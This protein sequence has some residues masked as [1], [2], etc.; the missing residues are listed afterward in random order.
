MG[1]RNKIPVTIRPKGVSDAQD[2]SNAF[3]GA[4]VSLQN[5]VLAYHTAN[6]FVPRPAAVKVVDFTGATPANPNGVISEMV[7]IGSRVY[8]MVSSAQFAGKD[9]PFCYDL[10]TNAFIPIAGVI[11]AL[12][13]NSPNA[14]GDWVPPVMR[15]IT[16]T[17]ILCTHPGFPGG[18]IPGVYFGWIDTS[19]Y[20]QNVIGNTTNGSN[21][22]SSLYTTIGNSAPIL[23]GVQPGQLITNV[24]FPAGTYVISCQNGTFSL[25]T[26]GNTTSGSNAL[27]GI[28]S[29]AGVLP[30]MTVSGPGIPSGTY[31]LTVSGATATMSQNATA[32]SAA[33]V[34]L[35]F[36]GGGSITVSANAT[37]SVNT[38][39]VTVSGGTPAAPRWGAG[40]FNSNSITTIP[41]CCY[42][43]NSR[44]YMGSGPYLVYSDPLMPLQVSAASQALLIGDSTDITALAG[45]PL[46]SQLTGGVQQSMTVFKGAGTLWQVTGD[47]AADNFSVDGVSYVINGGSASDNLTI[48]AV[49]GSVGTL[50]PRSIVGTPIGTMFMAVDGLRVLG[51]TGTLSEPLNTDGKGVAI[52]FLNALYPSRIVSAY[53]ENIYRATVQDASQPGNPIVE[54]WFDINSGVW[55]GPHTLTTR[56]AQPYISGASFLVAPLSTNG[57]IWRSDAI[58]NYNSTF[59]DPNG[60]RLQCQYRTV[61]LPDNE[62]THWNKVLQGTLAMSLNNS[63]VVNVSVDDDRGATLGAASFSGQASAATLWGGS[64]WGG[65][66][67]GASVSLLR[68]YFLK[69]PN[70]LVFRQARVT[71]SFQASAGQ[72]IGNLYVAAQPVNMNDV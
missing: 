49:A 47:A 54:Y 24:N 44:A 2:G 55:T 12:L 6:C 67:W 38:T 62:Q 58:P 35:N 45:V 51:L 30:G 29:T 3:P 65:G 48:N 9:E 13:P 23:Q 7:V 19:S 56:A 46:T 16:N 27:S 26:T 18:A 63:D 40:N 33:A 72:A 25:N 64:T 28:G 69:F 5:L 1:L 59:T 36:S 41:K 34:A 10:L 32:T 50:A 57:Q 43:F 21:V 42:G 66:T 39:S 15:A 22:I 53:A 60:N 17:Y 8:G 37:A 71:A 11:N 61:L 70:P 68:E 4:M 14:T 52:P 20:S 31:L